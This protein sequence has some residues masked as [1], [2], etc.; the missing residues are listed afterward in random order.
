MPTIGNPFIPGCQGHSDLGRIVRRAII[1]DEHTYFDSGLRKNAFNT[2]PQE[3]SVVVTGNYDINSLQVFSS[4][5]ATRLRF[6]LHAF[7]APRFIRAKVDVYVC[8]A[9]F[10]Q[11]HTA[12]NSADRAS[13][14]EPARFR[15]L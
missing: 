12:R 15:P 8:I 2:F 10:V 6:A 1:Q 13:S 14:R 5:G 9:D 11:D 3:V 7:L 4:T